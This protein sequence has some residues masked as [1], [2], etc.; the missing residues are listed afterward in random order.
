MNKLL[1]IVFNY[2]T[3]TLEFYKEP[4]D[5]KYKFRFAGDPDL[6]ETI[7]TQCKTKRVKEESIIYAARGIFEK[8]DGTSKLK[9]GKPLP[10]RKY[11]QDDT[12]WLNNIC[13]AKFGK[14]I[15]SHFVSKTGA[16]HIPIIKV[17]VVLPD[18][19]EAFGVGK[20]PKAAR[21]VAAKKL[22]DVVLREY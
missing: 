20:N 5:D 17:K 19:K 7:L 13:Q 21:K 6:T 4:G 22:L 12:S 16:P 14:N 8:L 18:G 15:E 2:E 9:K 3:H 10:L 11:G 1:S